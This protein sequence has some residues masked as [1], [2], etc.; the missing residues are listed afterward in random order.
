MGKQKNIPQL[1]FPEYEGE[2]ESKTIQEIFDFKN[3][4]NKEKEFF[5]KGT[6]IVNFTDVFKENA[7]TKENIRGLVEVTE[8]EKVNY[9]AKKGDV[10]FTRT[11]ETINEIG[12]AATLIDEIADCVFSGFVLRARQ[13]SNDLDDQFKKYC[14]ST[15]PIRREIITKSSFTTRALTSGTLLN[16]VILKFPYSKNEQQK[17][18]S[19][20]TAI[21]Q[22]IS[23]LKQKK[24][25][26]EQYKKW[27]MQKIFSQEIK[28]KDDNGQEFTK[29]EKFELGDLL[30]H[31]AIRN[32]G[33]KVDLVLSVSN[34]KGFITQSEQFD[35]HRVASIDVSNYKIVSKDD[36][37]YNPSR[38]NVGSIARLTDYKEGIVSP[39]Y[40]VFG[41]R[42]LLNAI[43]FENWIDTHKFKYLVRI[44]CSGSVRDSL[45][46]EDMCNF[47][48][49]LPSQPEQ[50]K[51]ANFLSAIDEKINYTQKQ[52]EKVEVWK[53]GL[54]QQMFV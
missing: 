20:F 50:T 15:E 43:F 8:K 18:A 39:M 4:L 12:M 7:L 17:I 25:L 41:L 35:N 5:G 51:I 2:W 19:F 52:I 49:K 34:T 1:R 11:S 13:K 53:K 21:D 44:S 31:K 24:N 42:E 9:S 48:I 37:A 40:V 29:W 28:F 26:L 36:F 54:M 6:P 47:P 46:F 10:F 33:C 22:K 16:K 23:Q 38:I 3:G 32:K 14:F 30:L 45:S 27:V